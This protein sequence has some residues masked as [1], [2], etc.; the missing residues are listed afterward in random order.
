MLDLHVHLLGHKDREATEENIS[1]FLRV[2]QKE[3]IRQIG[4]SDHDLYWEDL[5]FDLIREAALKHPEIQ[6]R[7]GLEVDY[8]EGEE[9]RIADMIAS[10]PFD[11]II[12]SVHEIGGWFFDFPEEEKTHLMKDSDQLYSQY[13]YHVEKSAV[14]GLFD[15]VGHFDLIKLFGVRPKTDVRILAARALEAIKDHQL[16]V[17][18]NTNGRYK[19]VKEF[20]PEYK[21][22]ELIHRMEIPFTLGSDAHEAAVV[23]RDI[24]EACHLLHKIGVK[25]VSG[26]Q[27]R[28]REIFS[29]R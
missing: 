7:V 14:S 13:F 20:Y 10:Y 9:R 24:P 15:V 3:G 4:F 5:D 26:Y 22:I 21:L 28:Q 23:G 6:V 17:E 19:P 27:L 25:N 29:L 16:A 8:Q 2:A 1:S 11:Y 18:I 12:G